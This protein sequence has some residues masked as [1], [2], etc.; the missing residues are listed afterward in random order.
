MG[1]CTLSRMSILLALLLPIVASAQTLVSGATQW[2]PYTFSD[3]GGEPKGIAVEVARQVL[4]QAG[5]QA[6]FV[7][8]PTNR[9]KLMEQQGR[10]DLNYADSPHWSAESDGVP[11]LFSHPYLNVKEHLFFLAS[12]PAREVPLDQLKSLN[13]GGVRGYHYPSLETA[14]QHRQLVRLDTSREDALMELLV[15]GR[16]DA[17]VMADDMFSYLLHA[18]ALDP[19]LFA[20]GPQIST[21][22]LAIKLNPRHSHYLPAINQAIQKM[23]ERGTVEDIRRGFVHDDA[24]EVLGV[25]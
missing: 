18:R 23:L 4:E 19:Q 16:V 25:R 8:Y 10:V 14:F 3:E 1:Y 17:I 12:H 21:A 6:E 9:L 24:Q 22:P 20:R 13:V 7:F 2:A 15:L 11:F 5:I